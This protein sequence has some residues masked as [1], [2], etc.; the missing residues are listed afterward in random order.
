MAYRR[1]S[2]CWER[3]EEVGGS[4]LAARRATS[5]TCAVSPTT[6]AMWPPKGAYAKMLLRAAASGSTGAMVNARPKWDATTNDRE[7][8]ASR[9]GNKS[10]V[11]VK[12]ALGGR[13]AVVL[14]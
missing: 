8:C 1:R 12:Q 5:R 4:D 9:D 6:S 13:H 14:F 2:G 3:V 11:R 7:I 10:G